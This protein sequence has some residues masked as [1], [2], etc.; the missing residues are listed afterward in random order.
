M[1]TLEVVWTILRTLAIPR[2]GR[3]ET[4]V[5]IQV[6]LNIS[7]EDEEPKREIPKKINCS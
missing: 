4:P 2:S 1:I 7:P 6:F 5:S 3:G